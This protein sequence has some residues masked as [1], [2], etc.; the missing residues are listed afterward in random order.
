MATA[1]NTFEL[2]EA[3]DSTPCDFVI[4]DIGMVASSFRVARQ[5]L[6][7]LEDADTG[8]I[9][10]EALHV[11]IPNERIAQAR[12]AAEVL[13]DAVFTKFPFPAGMRS[14]AQSQPTTR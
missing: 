4:S 1:R 7:R 12:R 9:K 5:L 14:R 8:R 10:L 11:P 3:V 2:A 13:G 6:E